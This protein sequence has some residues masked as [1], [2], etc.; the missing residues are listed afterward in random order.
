M[1]LYCWWPCLIAKVLSL[2]RWGAM[3]QGWLSPVALLLRLL[4][5]VQQFRWAATANPRACPTSFLCPKCFTMFANQL[6]WNAKLHSCFKCMG[7]CIINLP[8]LG[9]SHI[10]F[11]FKTTRVPSKASN[12]WTFHT[13]S[14][15][16]NI[17]L[18][19]G[20]HWTHDL[21][22]WVGSYHCRFALVILDTAFQ[23]QHITSHIVK[24]PVILMVQSS[25]LVFR[26]FLVLKTK[27]SPT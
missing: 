3:R 26:H 6:W 19:V 21:P 9:C 24:V 11:C 23:T 1:S 16:P 4:A 20:V 22:S 13:L 25:L 27:S 10:F 15:V 7:L 14:R 5:R 8:H 17:P 18:K 12:S 2:S